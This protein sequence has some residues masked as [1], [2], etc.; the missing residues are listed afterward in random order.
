MKRDVGRLG[1]AYFQKICSEVGLKANKSSDNDTTGWDYVI[2]FP[3]EDKKL[4]V[5]SS[6][7]KD[8][9]KTICKV[10]IKS[11]D[12]KYKKHS[13]RLSSMKRF[14]NEPTPS[15]FVFFEFDGKNDPQKMFL[16]HTGED[17]IGKTLKRLR[18]MDSS[19]DSKTNL[20]TLTINYGDEHEVYPITG[21]KLQ[22]VF[23]EHIGTDTHLYVKKKIE[24]INSVGFEDLRFK[25]SFKTDDKKSLESMVN[26]V[27]GLDTYTNVSS[28][29]LSETRFGIEKIINDCDEGRVKL[30]PSLNTEKVSL[31]SLGKDSDEIARIDATVFS[32]GGIAQIIPDDMKKIRLNSDLVDIIINPHTN[33]ANMNLNLP[34]NDETIDL[35]QCYDQMNFFKSCVENKRIGIQRKGENVHNL[36]FVVNS[37]D[38]G[39]DFDEIFEVLGYACEVLKENNI[40]KCNST[41]GNIGIQKMKLIASVMSYKPVP[42]S[43]ITV[44]LNEKQDF[45]KLDKVSV[46]FRVVLNFGEWNILNSIGLTGDVS[47]IKSQPQDSLIFYEPRLAA[48]RKIK[49]KEKIEKIDL[50]NL[51]EKVMQELRDL[52]YDYIITI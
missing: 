19:Q 31:V 48:K 45:K 15:F 36:E 17:L 30:G 13:I 34:N 46:V 41:L 8:F 37:A 28:I 33:Y 2:E 20:K 38:L 44:N 42:G 23:L 50:D 39:P 12:T 11:S 10:Q 4:M 26:S 40:F 43:M 25:I 22:S 6:L 9:S 16:V 49:K 47:L 21:A 51:E 27:L 29:K 32:T 3:D 14:V 1:E 24:T 35:F 52:N 7:E 5:L 18:Q